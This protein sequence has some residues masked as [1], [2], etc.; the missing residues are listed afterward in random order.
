MLYSAQL[1]GVPIGILTSSITTRSLGPD[2]YGIL[3]FYYTVTGFMLLF[4]R[5]GFASSGG[6]LIAQEKDNYEVKK[7]IGA[8]ITI[9]ILIGIVYSLFVFIFSFFVDDIFNTDIGNILKWSSIPILFYPFQFMINSITRGSNK[10][11]MLSFYQI[12]PKIIYMVGILIFM[13]L[14]KIGVI[15]LIILTVGN[16]V[17]IN[18]LIITIWKPSFKELRLNIRKLLSKNREYGIHLYLGQISD[19]S[20]YGLDGILIS[21]FVNTT[22]LGFYNLA[23]TITSPMVMLSQAL[24]SSLFKEFVHRE[25]IPKKI[26]YLNFLWLMSCA[27]G[28]ILIGKYIVFLFFSNQFLPVVSLII[29]WSIASFFQGAYQPYNMFLGAKGEWRMGY[30][31]FITTP[32]NLIG[33]II[34]IPRYGAYGAAIASAISMLFWYILFLLLYFKNINTRNCKETHEQV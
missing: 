21:Y 29:P 26:I 6:L 23:H 32:I 9:F 2:N 10:I 11:G 3:A 20:T 17:I 12:V 24:S 34:L 14:H 4:F 16:T 1:I 25:R 5:F 22:Q 31:A 30:L 15:S 18:L 13:A 27:V 7:L 19:Q 8:M 28:I 33:N